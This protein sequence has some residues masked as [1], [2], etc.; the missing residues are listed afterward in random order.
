MFVVFCFAVCL[1]CFRKEKLEDFQNSL[2]SGKRG[3][4]NEESVKRMDYT[5]YI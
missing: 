2:K 4:R 3:Q 1:L 5:Y